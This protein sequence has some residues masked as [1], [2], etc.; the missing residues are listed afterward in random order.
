MYANIEQLE[1]EVAAFAANLSSTNELTQMMQLIATS[2]AKQCAD[3]QAQNTA[4][5]KQ[6]LKLEEAAA[7][8]PAAIRADYQKLSANFSENFAQGKAAYDSYIKA[9]EESVAKVADIPERL[10]AKIDEN[11]QELEQAILAKLTQLQTPLEKLEKLGQLG[12]IFESCDEIKTT[13][14]QETRT[15]REEL[16]NARGEIE[17]AQGSIEQWQRDIEKHRQESECWQVAEAD[18]RAAQLTQLSQS[19]HANAVKLDAIAAAVERLDM[20]EETPEKP[21]IKPLIPVYIGIGIAVVLLILQIIGV[22]L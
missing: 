4:L 2:V 16:E 10:E 1:K 14:A 12:Q 17:N 5:A 3:V 22:V 6:L 9:L 7:N 20:V 8:A 19:I 15:R 21:S 18:K 11:A 13:L